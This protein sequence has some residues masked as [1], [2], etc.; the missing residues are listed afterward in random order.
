MKPLILPYQGVDPKIADTAFIAPTASIIGDVTIGEKVGVWFNCVIRGDVASVSIG[1][2]SNIQDGT[3]IHVSRYNGPTVIGAGVT[4]GHKALLHA[5]RLED[6]SFVGMGA[7][8]MDNA[9]VE[10]GGMVAAGALITPG[11]RVKSGQLWAGSPAKFFRD[12]TPE[13][14]AFIK[15][16]EENYVRHVDEYREI[17]SL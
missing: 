9:V 7:T 15:E 17:V 13:E 16:S 3:V 14:I 5:C 2:R 8:V 10:S 12:M 11:K 4:V 1:D 6:G